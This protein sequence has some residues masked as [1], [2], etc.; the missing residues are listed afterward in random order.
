VAQSLLSPEGRV[1]LE[2]L[3][4]RAGADGWLLYDFRDQ[5]PLAH[6]L[7]GLG[8]TTRRAFAFLPRRGDPVVLRHAIEAS[9]WRRWPWEERTYSGWRELEPG[10]VKLLSGAKVVAMEVSPGGGVPTMDRVPCGI[11][12]LVRKAGVRVVSSGDLVTSFHSRWSARGLELHRAA[13]GC[14]RRIALDAF[15]RAAT[16]ADGPAPITEAALMDQIHA[17]LLQVGLSD[18]TGCIVAAGSGSA[19]PHYHPEGVGRPLLRDSVLLIDLWGRAP[20]GGIPAD[21][22]WMG[23]LGTTPPD[24]VRRVWEAVRDARDRA[25]AFLSERAASGESVRG[26]EVDRVARASL[27]EHAL[28][29]WFVHRLGHSIDSDLHGSGPDLDDLEARDDRVLL[30]GVGFSV[31]PGVYLPG[32]FGVRSEVN[33]HW[34]GDGLEVTP[35]EIQRDLL[36]FEG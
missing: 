30:P 21:Q 7:L 33:V 29:R 10:L 12:E 20:D 4:D 1:E 14:V 13:A 15:Q 35:G 36:L 19:D 24:R 22:T 9:A 17:E 34:R 16:A 28:D 26:F 5:N 6:R 27:A 8:K 31:E 18:Q 25:L 11:V 3:L 2:G 23:F 32:E